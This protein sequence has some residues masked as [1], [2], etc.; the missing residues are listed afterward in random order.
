MKS[1]NE[2]VNKALKAMFSLKK[3]LSNFS[4]FPTKLSS[5]L[6]DS[7]IRPIVTY[8]SEVWLADY[9]INLNNIDLLPTEKLQHK[10][11]KSVLGIT[12]NS[13]NLASRC[14]MG[15]NP[16]VLFAI[17]LMFKY[18]ER[19]RTL[20]T[21]RLLSKAF[22]TDQDLHINGY[23]S[24]YSCLEKT[25]RSAGIKGNFNFLDSETVDKL[26]TRFYMQ[27]TKDNLNNLRLHDDS[28]L[29]LYS[30]VFNFNDNVPD[31]LKLNLKQTCTSIITKFRLS[32]HK[33]NIER[34]RYS[35]PKVPREERICKFCNEVESESH[36]IL[37]CKTYDSFRDRLLKEFDIDK[38]KLCKDKEFDTLKLILNPRNRAQATMLSKYLS[39]ALEIR[40]S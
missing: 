11:C 8:G 21:N 4:Q 2:I 23:K 26:L 10:F 7:L 13:S 9:I 3:K 15:R 17:K 22:Q 1:L 12:R 31:Y 5:K 33:L 39:K 16:I 37:F 36:F 35:R 6:F 27:Q 40:D 29:K 24:W 18:Y 28:K 20:P 32:S 19:L 34:G 30:N 38:L 14:E 25:L